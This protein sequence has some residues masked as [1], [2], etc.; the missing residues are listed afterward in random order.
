M[1]ECKDFFDALTRDGIAFFAGVPDSL[2]KNVCAYITD[3]V[4][5][6]SHVISANE[7]GA[8]GLAMG[9]YLATGSPAL[10]YM[11]N[12]GQGNAV[13]PLMSLA[14]KEVY[15]I[16]M[17]LMVGWRGEPGTK[18][19]PQHV[20]QGKVTPALFEAMGISHKIL[21]DEMD[22]ARDV[23]RSLVRETRQTNQPVAL[24]VRKGTFAP[25]ALEKRPENVHSLSREEAIRTVVRFLDER[26]VIVSTTGKASRELF[27]IREELGQGHRK[28]FLTVGGMGH[29]SQI[30]LGIALAQPDRPVCCLD[31]D[32]AALMHAGGMGI[33]GSYS[34]A[35][36][37]KHVLLNNGTHDSVGG[38]PTIGFDVDFCGMARAMGYPHA[39]RVES[40]EALRE[41]LPGFLR[42]PGAGL[43]E[44][45]VAGGA[46]DDLGRPT[47]RPVANKQ[48]M[49][50]FLRD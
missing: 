36:R 42:E 33:I 38:Q 37:Y 12:S 40:E 46:R 25:Y 26:A 21:P 41:V 49:M 11:Q 32:G 27:E 20:K 29:A 13:N 31:G 18:D 22:A 30:A 16:P 5:A 8:V 23:V 43:L 7:G 9:H 35:R 28:D 15:A 47:V 48:A 39:L 14:D 4:P 44:I 24:L 6:S 50:E 34:A 1:L 10:L 45:R 19:E 17:L 3:H 2:L